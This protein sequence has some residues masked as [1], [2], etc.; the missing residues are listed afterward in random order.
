MID[1]FTIYNSDGVI[2]RSGRGPRES[3][4]MVPEGGDIIWG[5]QGDVETEYVSE[6]KILLK[7]EI[8]R[9]NIPEG[10]T[11]LCDGAVVCENFQGGDLVFDKDDKDTFQIEV[12]HPHYLPL[13][14]TV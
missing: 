10:S 6:G 3:S 5:T 8:D 1:F 11:I 7:L 9:D 13:R 4:T 12:R 2:I 14:F